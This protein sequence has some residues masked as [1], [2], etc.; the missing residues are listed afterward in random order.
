MNR[1]DRRR[2]AKGGDRFV[3]HCNGCPN[4]S[5]PVKPGKDPCC[6]V[7][8]IERNGIRDLG[9]CQ[10]CDCSKGKCDACG[11]T[12]VHWLGCSVVGLE[13]IPDKPAAGV[14]H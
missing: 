10:G 9:V 11:M 3:A 5:L 13:A 14:V 7:T 1:A 4:G 8:V 12:G 2:A 6:L